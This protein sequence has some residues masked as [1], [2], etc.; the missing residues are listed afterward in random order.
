[1]ESS[2]S[3]CEEIIK[4]SYITNLIRRFYGKIIIIYRS[5][6]LI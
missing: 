2:F 1:M 4:Y 5:L 6:M 3:F